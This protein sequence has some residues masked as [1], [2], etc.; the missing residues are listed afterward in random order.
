VVVEIHRGPLRLNQGTN[1]Q[2]A[3][4]NP[5]TYTP[6]PSTGLGPGPGTPSIAISVFQII[7]HLSSDP[8]PTKFCFL[9]KT[10]PPKQQF[11]AFA[12][13][14]GITNPMTRTQP[15]HGSILNCKG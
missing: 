4:N 12:N 6:I 2:H 14:V 5:A 3:T 9:L 8:H 11:T 13:C 1:L 10:D 7:P 15:P